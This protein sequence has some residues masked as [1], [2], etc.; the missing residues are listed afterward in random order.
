ML[1]PAAQKILD[2]ATLLR[3]DA[4]RL[5][6]LRCFFL[7]MDEEPEAS[8][9]GQGEEGHTAKL[10]RGAVIESPTWRQA[11]K[12]S[13]SSRVTL[14]IPISERPDPGRVAVRRGEGAVN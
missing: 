13:G 8:L 14:L 10:V 7:V 6:A 1:S 11:A 5:V 12:R 9:I 4:E 3:R 2:I